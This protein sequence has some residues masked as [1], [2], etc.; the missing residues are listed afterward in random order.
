MPDSGTVDFWD[1]WAIDAPRDNIGAAVVA[2]R[3]QSMPGRVA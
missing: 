1:E 2:W 3:K